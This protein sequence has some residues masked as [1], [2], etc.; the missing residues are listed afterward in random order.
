LD[1]GY[2]NRT[3]EGATVEAVRASHPPWRREKKDEAKGYPAAL[4][5]RA[6]LRMVVS[7]ARHS[8]PLGKKADYYLVE[9]CALL[10]YRRCR[11]EF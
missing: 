10:W 3:G 2:D 4:G 8:D 7:L 1:K 6:N 9:A 5:G 11:L